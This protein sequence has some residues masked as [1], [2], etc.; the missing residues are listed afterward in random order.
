M[1][2]EKHFRAGAARASHAEDQMAATLAGPDG[3]DRDVMVREEHSRVGDIRGIAVQSA[4][5]Q[6]RRAR[7]SD[8]PLERWVKK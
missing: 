7:T 6:G 2:R 1:A 4:Q 3:E 5:Q 8:G